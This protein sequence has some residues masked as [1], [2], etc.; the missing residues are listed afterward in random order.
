MNVLWRFKRFYIFSIFLNILTFFFSIS[1]PRFTCM[2]Q[3]IMRIFSRRLKQWTTFNSTITVHSCRTDE[4]PL[5]S[6]SDWSLFRVVQTPDLWTFCP[7]TALVSTILARFLPH[8]LANTCT[9]NWQLDD[10]TVTA[11]LHGHY[12]G[13][14]TRVWTVCVYVWNVQVYWDNISNSRSIVCACFQNSVIKMA[15]FRRQLIGQEGLAVA[16]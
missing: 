2:L 9:W 5:V 4:I 15:Q 6:Q 3:S 12:R 10:C 16:G 1:L 11:V 7:A 8:L 13:H 14:Y